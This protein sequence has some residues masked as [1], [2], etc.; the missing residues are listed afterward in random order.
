MPCHSSVAQEVSIVFVSKSTCLARKKSWVQTS[1]SLVKGSQM[2][3]VAKDCSL[4]T[5]EVLLL[6]VGNTV[7]GGPMS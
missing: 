6:R 3:G 4:R 7:L 2:G 5:S 1:T